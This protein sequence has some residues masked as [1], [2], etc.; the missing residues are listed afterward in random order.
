LRQICVI[1]E[2]LS[3]F[4]KKLVSNIVG[5]MKG[6]DVPQTG[7]IVHRQLCHFFRSDIG[8]GMAI[9]Q[10]LDVNPEDAMRKK[11]LKVTAPAA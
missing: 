11:H 2:V 1:R 3:D 8:L 9:A 6:I 7:D 5:A 10:G 4:E